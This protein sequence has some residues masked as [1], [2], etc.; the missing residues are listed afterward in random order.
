[1]LD[2]Y[3]KHVEERKAL[4]IPPFPSAPMTR[5]RSV[6]FLKGRRRAWETR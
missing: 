1:M 5:P 4:G 6:G 3:F 2:A